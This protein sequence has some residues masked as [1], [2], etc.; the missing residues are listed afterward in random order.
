MSSMQR[1][2]WTGIDAE[3]EAKVLSL[4][5]LLLFHTFCQHELSQ[6]TYVAGLC[7]VQLPQ[8]QGRNA[9]S[10]LFSSGRSNIC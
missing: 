1:T 2:D 5:L 10:H 3:I 4:P 9:V 7:M 8:G 6:V